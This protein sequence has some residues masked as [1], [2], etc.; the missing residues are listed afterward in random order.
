MDE[1]EIILLGIA[2]VV[3]TPAI[4]FLAENAGACNRLRI[5]SV[6]KSRLISINMLPL[7]KHYQ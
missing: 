6:E 4:F 7:H 3:V 2:A 1:E 5:D